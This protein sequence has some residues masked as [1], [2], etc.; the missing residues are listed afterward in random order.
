MDP[1]KFFNKTEQEE[2]LT[3][4]KEAEKNTSGEV[5]V[6]IEGTCNTD[7]K[8]RAIQVF[9]KIGM[10]KTNLKNGVLFYLAVKSK[11]FAVIGDIGINEKVEDNFWDS[12][13]QTVIEHFSKGE[14]T[15]GLKFGILQ[16]GEKLASHFPYMI[17]DINELSDDIS[18]GEK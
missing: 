16:T 8:E 11:Q 6:H 7:P 9:E 1:K 18:F 17:D 3:A 14:Y 15:K 4:I 5:R 10:H 12:I 13:K 2:I